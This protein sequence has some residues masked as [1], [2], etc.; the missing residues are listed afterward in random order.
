MSIDFWSNDNMG[1]FWGFVRMLLEL[2]QPGVMIFVATLGVGLLISII[3][4]AVRK[5]DK[6]EED[7]EIEVRRY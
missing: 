2:V 6:D 3:V 1:T 4:K 5:A 7:E